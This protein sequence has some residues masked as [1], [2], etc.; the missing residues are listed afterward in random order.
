M[1]GKK[2]GIVGHGPSIGALAA[3]MAMACITSGIHPAMAS[4]LMVD[5]RPVAAPQP[6]IHTNERAKARR[7]RQLEKLRRKP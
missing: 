4:R 6:T 1:T 2:I 7:L 5:G 3:I